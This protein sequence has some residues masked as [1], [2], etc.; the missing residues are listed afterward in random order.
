MHNRIIL[1]IEDNPSDGKHMLRALRGLALPNDIILFDDGAEALEY[2]TGSNTSVGNIMQAAPEC[3][4]LDLSLPNID[5]L[6]ILRQLRIQDRTRLTPV[7]IFTSSKEPSDLRKSYELGANSYVHK[8]IDADEFTLA[9]QQTG[10]YWVQ[11]N[12]QPP[13]AR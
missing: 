5:G 6:D 9:V 11:R 8:P 2:I 4:F 10:T 7:V 12:V 3:V 13:I 1:V